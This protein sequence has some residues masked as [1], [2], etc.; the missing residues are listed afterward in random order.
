MSTAQKVADL[1]DVARRVEVEAV[2]LAQV[3]TTAR[4]VH[5]HTE[6][7]P[8]AFSLSRQLRRA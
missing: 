7:T 3:A 6:Q 2:P 1:E 8:A 5:S 4:M